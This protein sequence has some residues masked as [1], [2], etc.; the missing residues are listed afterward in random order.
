MITCEFLLTK[1]KYYKQMT[2][3]ELL[4]GV[5]AIQVTG[6]VRDDKVTGIEYDSR[7]GEK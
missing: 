7:K 2:L 1:I 4:N 6:N 5:T 3:T